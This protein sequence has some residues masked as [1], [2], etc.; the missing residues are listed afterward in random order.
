M[1]FDVNA[2]DMPGVVKAVLDLVIAFGVEVS[3]EQYNA[4]VALAEA[5]AV[6][7]DDV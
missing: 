6:R 7:D 3:E 4:I 2:V 1:E 5:V